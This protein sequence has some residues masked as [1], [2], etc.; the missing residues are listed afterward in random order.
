MDTNKSRRGKSQV[1]VVLNGKEHL[2]LE[3]AAASTGLSKSALVRKALLAYLE[4][5]KKLEL[6]TQGG[7]LD[8]SE[9]DE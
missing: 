3:E 2:I 4:R 9:K 7:A 1:N 8:K 5:R 6:K